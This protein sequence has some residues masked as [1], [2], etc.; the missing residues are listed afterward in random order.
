VER[1]QVGPREPDDD[2]GKGLSGDGCPDAS[3]DESIERED[4]GVE[5]CAQH[6]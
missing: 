6:E 2:P 1:H 3:S 4:R 5:K